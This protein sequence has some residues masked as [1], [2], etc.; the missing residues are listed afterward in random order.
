MSVLR[1]LGAPPSQPATSAATRSHLQVV[2]NEQRG[3]EQREVRDRVAERLARE[4]VAV[5]EIEPQGV[6][7][8]RSAE[9]S[10]SDQVDQAAHAGGERQQRDAEKDQRVQQHLQAR[11]LL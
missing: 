3:E 1:N 11:V 9:R 10:G 4:S 6:A 2:I 8:E 5:G 7:D